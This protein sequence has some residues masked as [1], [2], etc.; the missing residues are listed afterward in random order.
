[1]KREW[2]IPFSEIKLTERVAEGSF[3]VVM[4][5][6][7]NNADV[8]VKVLKSNVDD[9]DEL[10]ESFE[11]EVSILKS[12]RHPN[13]VLFMGVALNGT[14]RFIVTEFMHGKSLDTIIHKSSRKT[15]KSLHNNILFTRKLELLLD[16]VKGM[17]YLHNLTPQIVHRDLKPSVCEQSSI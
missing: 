15:L 6:R 11:H 7:Y 1:V 8:A 14:N 5:G 3:G 16:V 9:Q 12:L 2:V 17:L 13:I 10:I 4:K